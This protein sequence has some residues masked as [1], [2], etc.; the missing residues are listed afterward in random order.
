MWVGSSQNVRPT[1]CPFPC[2]ERQKPPFHFPEEFR[3][4]QAYESLGGTNP[5]WAGLCLWGFGILADAGIGLAVAAASPAT[6][7]VPVSVH[8]FPLRRAAM[9]TDSERWGVIDEI[10]HDIG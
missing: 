4:P 10:W 6:C 3:A 1:E 9:I 7:F 5:R 8:D 2:I